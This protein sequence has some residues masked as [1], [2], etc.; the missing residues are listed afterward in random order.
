M[1][2]HKLIKRFKR[3]TNLSWTIENG[4]V[5]KLYIQANDEWIEVIPKNEAELKY[6]E[7]KQEIK[8]L[9]KMLGIEI[10]GGK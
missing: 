10:K 3:W 6:T 9:E 1:K 7:L 5:S 8:E 4:E 2:F